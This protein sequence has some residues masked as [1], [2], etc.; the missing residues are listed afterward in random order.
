MIK[1]IRIFALIAVIG[2]TASSC[3]DDEPTD[4]PDTNSFTKEWILDKEWITESGALRHQFNTDGTY[5]SVG[6]W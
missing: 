4:E 2:F 6:N 5:F 1:A 3:G